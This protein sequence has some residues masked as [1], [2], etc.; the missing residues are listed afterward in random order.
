[1]TNDILLDN[2]RST[3]RWYVDYL[4]RLL[5]SQKDLSRGIKDRSWRR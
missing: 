1:M 5:A 3:S 2:S 4:S